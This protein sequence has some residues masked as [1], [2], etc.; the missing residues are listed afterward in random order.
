MLLFLWFYHGHYLCSHLL[1]Y[2]SFKRRQGYYVFLFMEHW[3][4][5]GSSQS[6]VYYLVLVSIYFLDFLHD[7]VNGNFRDVYFGLNG[8]FHPFFDYRRWCPGSF[9][10]GLD[11]WRVEYLILKF[12]EFI[13]PLPWRQVKTFG[14]WYEDNWLFLHVHLVKFVLGMLDVKEE[15]KKGWFW[16]C[17]DFL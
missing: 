2:I 6:W 3:L 17:E 16:I 11:E 14:E 13:E 1:V 5:H 4:F 9:L 12:F 7:I 10:F 15:L 8:F